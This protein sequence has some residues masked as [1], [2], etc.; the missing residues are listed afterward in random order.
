MGE[1]AM[2]IVTSR[3]LSNIQKQ[4]ISSILAECASQESTALTYPLDDD[5]TLHIIGYDT[6]GRPVSVIGLYHISEYSYEGTAFTVPDQRRGGYFRALL[7]KA[8]RLLYAL[9]HRTV[10]VSWVTDEDSL[11]AGRVARHIRAR[12]KNIELSMLLVMDNEYYAD[13]LSGLAPNEFRL[14]PM[15]PSSVMYRVL[16]AGQP[17]A[18]FSLLR[19]DS[20]R[21]A[22]LY[23]FDVDKNLR[24][25]GVGSRI[26]PHILRYI[27]ESGYTRV[28]LQVSES[29]KA[30]CRIYRHAG[31]RNVTRLG[32]YIMKLG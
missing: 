28:S 16:Q 7:K 10:T 12:R 32:Y 5:D 3:D 22:F 15:S 29:N 19:Y 18:S 27:Y 31:F 20:R 11:T 17:L 2:L 23:S 8:A 21:E 14:I 6:D 1:C 26:F 24:G 30:A 13:R 4:E 25:H 9:H